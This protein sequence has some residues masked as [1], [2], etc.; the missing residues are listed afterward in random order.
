MRYSTVANIEK[1]GIKYKNDAFC[2]FFFLINK[3]LEKICLKK[4]QSTPYRIR[5]RW[6]VP[7][8]N[9]P[10]LIFRNSGTQIGRITRNLVLDLG[11][12][13]WWYRLAIKCSLKIKSQKGLKRVNTTDVLHI[14]QSFLEIFAKVLQIIAVQQSPLTDRPSLEYWCR[15]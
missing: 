1:S 8:V 7:A 14:A 2:F 10:D 12:I 9:S 5:H 11:L 3:L 13:R 6:N 4:L 15:P